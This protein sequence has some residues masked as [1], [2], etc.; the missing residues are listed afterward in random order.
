MRAEQLGEAL[1]IRRMRVVHEPQPRWREG[2]QDLD[3]RVSGIAHP[4]PA[5]QGEQARELWREGA[6]RREGKAPRG[7]VVFNL[8]MVLC[9]SDLQMRENFR[10]RHA[11]GIFGDAMHE[12]RH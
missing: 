8:R 12:Y 3:E 9:M 10:A 5:P 11:T 2:L 4:H 6:D 1:A 7:E